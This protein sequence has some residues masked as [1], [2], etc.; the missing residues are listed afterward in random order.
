MSAPARVK[1]SYSSDEIRPVAPLE[2]D[3]DDRRSRLDDVGSV[4]GSFWDVASIQQLDAMPVAMGPI[5]AVLQCLAL[6]RLA[7]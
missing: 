3:R 7:Q 1:L 4:D 5:S 6:L 2:A